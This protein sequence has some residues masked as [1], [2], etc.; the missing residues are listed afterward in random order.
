MGLLQKRPELSA[1]DFR[2]H[3]RET[4]GTLAAQLPG[5]RR[6]HQNHIVERVQRGIEYARGPHDFDGF[7]E[8]WFED[9]PSMSA[10]FATEKTKQLAE[11]EA[12]FIGNL[13]LIT[14]IQHVVV[15]P[16]RGLPLVKRMST[17]KRRPDVSSEQFPREWFDVHST[18]V[19][20]LPEVRA[21]LRTLFSTERTA[22]AGLRATRT[23]RSTASWSYGFRISKAL[24]R[25]SHPTPARP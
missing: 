10:A 6:Y 1:P 24:M 19:K 16:R 7:S 13:K 4:H 9:L 18:L 25:D 14:A 5:L 15:E 22:V 8:P 2:R 11:D 21:I 23:Y 20:R 3:W 12:R 17:L